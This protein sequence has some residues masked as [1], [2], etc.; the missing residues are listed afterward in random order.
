M[1]PLDELPVG[2]GHSSHDQNDSERQPATQTSHSLF[3]LAACLKTAFCRSRRI[4]KFISLKT[5]EIPDTL[6]Q[7]VVSADLASVRE[8][9]HGQTSRSR[10]GEKTMPIDMIPIIVFMLGF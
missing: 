3:S 10:E 4:Q 6:L 5:K 8:R 7:T 9:K 2:D 1:L